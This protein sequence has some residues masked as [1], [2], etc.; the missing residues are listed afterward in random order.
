M[1]EHSK[2]V[3]STDG[4]RLCPHCGKALADCVCRQQQAETVR[5]DGKVRVSRSSKGRKGKAVTLVSGLPLPEAELKALAK[6]LR[7]QCG[8]GG[9]VKEGVVEIQGD[10]RERLVTLLRDIG[11]DA[12]AAGG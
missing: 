2:P 12:K 3:Y 8:T 6:K 11:Y 1:S 4:G 10:Q 9:T 7:Q 5:G